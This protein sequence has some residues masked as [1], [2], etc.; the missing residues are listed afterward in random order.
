MSLL[1]NSL[2]ILCSLIVLFTAGYCLPF[3]YFTQWLI[4]LMQKN[5]SSYFTILLVILV[6]N[7]FLFNIV[8]SELNWFL[9]HSL[10]FFTSIKPGDSQLCCIGRHCL[11]H[12]IDRI[13]SDTINSMSFS[14]ALF[15]VF[16]CTWVCLYAAMS[17][18]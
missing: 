4:F 13:S 1:I 9:P 12:L 15:L 3:V 16:V 18:T 11:F 17:I 10:D 2:R 8:H 6:L 14:V 5:C 7:S